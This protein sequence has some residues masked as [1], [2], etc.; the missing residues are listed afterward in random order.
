MQPSNP[1][2]VDLSLVSALFDIAP[3][4]P[5][6][7][8]ISVEPFGTTSPILKRGCL[9]P[10][11]EISWGNYLVEQND[12]IKNSQLSNAELRVAVVTLMLRLRYN[13]AWTEEHTLALSSMPLIEALY[14]FFCQERDRHAPSAQLLKVDSTT[15]GKDIAVEYAQKYKAVAVSRPDLSI[16]GIYYVFRS[17][18]D[19]PPRTAE[20]VF[21]WS[22]IAD[23]SEK[24]QRVAETTSKKK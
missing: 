11:E 13:P 21:T 3:T 12:R 16:F 5:I 1:N 8:V 23:F 10:K 22:I 6:S 24:P 4:Q 15:C 20:D 14:D 2:P 17:L 7:H 9:S 18:A 19:L